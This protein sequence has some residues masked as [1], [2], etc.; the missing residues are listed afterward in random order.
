MT[1]CDIDMYCK[2][3]N[4]KEGLATFVKIVG[5]VIDES[6]ISFLTCVDLGS[7]VGM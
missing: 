4:V 2:I 6:T 3:P 1:I 7:K 5:K